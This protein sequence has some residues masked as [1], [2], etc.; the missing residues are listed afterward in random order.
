MEF[1]RKQKDLMFFSFFCIVEKHVP[2]WY[3]EENLIL[4]WKYEKHQNH[5]FIYPYPLLQTEM[6][7]L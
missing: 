6:S 3:H 2:A 4:R 7:L 5:W 1:S